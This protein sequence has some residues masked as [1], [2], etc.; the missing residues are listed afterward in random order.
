MTTV[1]K[2]MRP[3]T[4][5]WEAVSEAIAALAGECGKLLPLALETENTCKSMLLLFLIALAK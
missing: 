3:G 4:S 5:W 2:D 1:A